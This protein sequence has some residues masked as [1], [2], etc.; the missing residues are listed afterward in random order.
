MYFL[1]LDHNIESLSCKIHIFVD[2]HQCS[3]QGQ[4]IRCKI[5]HQ[6]CNSAQRLSSIAN[7]GIYVVVLL[8]MNRYGSFPLLSAPHSL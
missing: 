4:V 8:G 2:H 3:A 7:S 1:L 5:R 6:G